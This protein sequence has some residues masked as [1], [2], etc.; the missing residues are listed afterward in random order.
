MEA[1]EKDKPTNETSNPLVIEKPGDP[2][3]K[4]PK[5]VFKKKFHNPNARVSSNYCLVEDLSQ[6]PCEISALKVLQSFPTKRDALITS[7]GSMDS[8]SLLVKFNLFDVKI[9]LTYHIYF[10]IDFFY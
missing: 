10:L 3:P 5:G 8:S 4:I 7:I 9:C 1:L 2:M 6:T